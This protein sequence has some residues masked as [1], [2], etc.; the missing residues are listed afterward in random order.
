MKRCILD[1]R[2]LCACAWRVEKLV[3]QATKMSVKGRNLSV[4]KACLRF[5]WI[6]DDSARYRQTAAPIAHLQI[7]LFQILSAS[8]FCVRPN[9]RWNRDGWMARKS[10]RETTGRLLPSTWRFR[11]I[12]FIAGVS[13]CEA[14]K[15]GSRK[16]S[17]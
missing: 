7:T 12:S 10:A 6:A 16:W 5:I 1:S 9:D 2:D 15:A 17:S 14:P 3:K 13:G 4:F 8:A 11:G